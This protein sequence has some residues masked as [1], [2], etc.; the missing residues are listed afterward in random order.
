MK[1][2]LKYLQKNR[3]KIFL[4]A[5]KEEQ[6]QSLSEEIRHYHR[7]IVITGGA[8]LVPDEGQEEKV[9]NEI[10]GT[11]TDCLVSMFSSPWQGAVHR[12]KESASKRKVM[13]RLRSAS[14]AELYRKEDRQKSE[15][16]L[17]EKVVSL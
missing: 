17:F 14:Y 11:E 16:I 2:F 3:K 10:N 1:L 7:G 13:D 4:L 5:D 9:I 15:D 12:R 6:I 8:A